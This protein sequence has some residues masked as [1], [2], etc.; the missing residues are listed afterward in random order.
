MN[1]YNFSRGNKNFNGEITEIRRGKF[2][3][4]HGHVTVNKPKRKQACYLWNLYCCPHVAIVFCTDFGGW[5]GSTLKLL[6]KTHQ[7]LCNRKTCGCFICFFSKYKSPSQKYCKIVLSKEVF[8]TLRDP[9]PLTLIRMGGGCF[10]P[11]LEVFLAVY[12]KDTTY[13]P[14]TPLTFTNYLF[15][16]F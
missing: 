5:G 14:Q 1:L 3:K 8:F 15:A 12:L 4:G 10:P 2:L 6:L 9:A 7:Y 13:V 16:T 11:P